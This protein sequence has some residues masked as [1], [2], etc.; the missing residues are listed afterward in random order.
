LLDLRN[1]GD[2]AGDR[3]RVVGYAAF[4]FTE[5]TPERVRNTVEAAAQAT[6]EAVA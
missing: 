6:E 1:S 2:T 3:S 4:A 5:P